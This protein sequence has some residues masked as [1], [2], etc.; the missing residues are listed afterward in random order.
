[1]MHV[2]EPGTV[3]PLALALT[4]EASARSA[5]TEHAPILFEEPEIGRIVDLVVAFS[6][7]S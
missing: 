3:V 6:F 4:D 1:M 5:Y 7:S 2:L